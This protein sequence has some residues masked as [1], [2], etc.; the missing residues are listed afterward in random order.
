LLLLFIVLDKFLHRVIMLTLS[1]IEA[2]SEP[3]IETS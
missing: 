1:C 3:S 2:A